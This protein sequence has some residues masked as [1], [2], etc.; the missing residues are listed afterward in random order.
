MHKSSSYFLYH[1]GTLCCDG[2]CG[3]GGAG[4][5]PADIHFS[6]SSNCSY[7][8]R[9]AHTCSP[10]T[11]APFTSHWTKTHTN[12]IIYHYHQPLKVKWYDEWPWTAS[13]HKSP[14]NCTQSIRRA[15]L[16]CVYQFIVATTEPIFSSSCRLNELYGWQHHQHNWNDFNLLLNAGLFWWSW[17]LY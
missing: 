14:T 4:V 13:I 5:A 8:S 10:P 1:T 17:F 6:V 11:T 7:C 15:V 16:Q 3:E 12:G 2:G 9:L